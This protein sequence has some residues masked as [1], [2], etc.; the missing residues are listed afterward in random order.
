M[1]ATRIDEITDAMIEARIGQIVGA[2]VGWTSPGRVPSQ[3]GCDSYNASAEAKA[4]ALTVADVHAMLER[5]GVFGGDATE[6]I[7]MAI[8][9][10]AEPVDLPENGCVEVF[11]S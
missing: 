2:S 1:T 7:D 5:H 3:A 8:S 4:L 6:E 9:I 11:Y 10:A